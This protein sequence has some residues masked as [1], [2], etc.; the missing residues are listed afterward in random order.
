MDFLKFVRDPSY[1]KWNPQ[2]VR[3]DSHDGGFLPDWFQGHPRRGAE[4]AILCSVPYQA[5]EDFCR[6]L[7]GELP[8]YRTLEQFF[9]QSGDPRQGRCHP[10]VNTLWDY[11][12]FLK[13]PYLQL[14]CRDDRTKGSKDRAMY[15]F[16]LY[17]KGEPA[18]DELQR[19]LRKVQ[20]PMNYCFR[21]YLFI[22][23]VPDE[24]TTGIARKGGGSRLFDTTPAGEVSFEARST[25]APGSMMDPGPTGKGTE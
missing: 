16:G 4:N 10:I 3:L 2:A 11:M 12:Q 7:G 21:S 14:W 24:Y 17:P 8:E 6:W 19:W 18:I 22:P 23:V 20:R 5:A 15:R 1:T 9:E 25:Q 13:V